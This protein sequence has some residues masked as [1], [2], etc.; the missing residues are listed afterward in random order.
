M[1]FKKTYELSFQKIRR[2]TRRNTSEIISDVG[3]LECLKILQKHFNFDVISAS[4]SNSSFKKSKI[5]IKCKP[6][7]KMEIVRLFCKGLYNFIE[8][9]ECE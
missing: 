3:I 2:N 6:A 8:E 4:F 9:V 7:D 5:I 1:F